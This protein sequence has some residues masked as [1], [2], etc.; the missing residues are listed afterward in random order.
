MELILY[1][2]V[3]LNFKIKMI[4]MQGPLKIHF[5]YLDGNI[6]KSVEVLMSDSCQ[7]PS[8]K[9]FDQRFHNPSRIDIESDYQ[10][11][12]TGKNNF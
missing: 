6:S 12:K 10:D 3:V 9:Q 5:Y 8:L 2:G 4:D 7:M 1:P 11:P